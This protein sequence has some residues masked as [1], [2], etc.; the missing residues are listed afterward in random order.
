MP[1]ETILELIKAGGPLFGPLL[2][3]ITLWITLAYHSLQRRGDIRDFRLYMALIDKKY[4][5]VAEL[6]DY[7]VLPQVN[8]RHAG[9]EGVL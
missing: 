5:T 9:W 4:F 6:R 7:G 8:E 3:I 1:G 2:F